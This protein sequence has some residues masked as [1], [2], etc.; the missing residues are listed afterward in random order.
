M[1]SEYQLRQAK[2][3]AERAK[4]ESEKRDI[5]IQK[6]KTMKPEKEMYTEEINPAISDA[7]S[8]MVDDEIRRM[9]FDP[10]IKKKEWDKEIEETFKNSIYK[11]I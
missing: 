11:N 9:G 6:Q 3:I 10:I 8:K 4:K 7:F 5:I 1:L 2:L